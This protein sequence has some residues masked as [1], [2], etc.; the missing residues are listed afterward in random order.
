MIAPALLLASL[1]AAAPAPQRPLPWLW[2]TAPVPAGWTALGDGAWE[3]PAAA[4]EPR[5]AAQIDFLEGRSPAD[6]IK[7]R[8]DPPPAM[9]KV[10]RL[11]SVKAGAVEHRGGWL[12]VEAEE[13]SVDGSKVKAYYAALP[14]PAGVYAAS[15]TGKEP[16]FSAHKAEAVALIEGF[17]RLPPPLRFSALPVPGKFSL[18][19]P[20]GAWRAVV[21]GADADLRAIAP[22]SPGGGAPGMLLASTLDGGAAEAAAFLARSCPGGA[23][24]T[25]S[26][27]AGLWS[28]A[29]ASSRSELVMPEAPAAGGRVY[30]SRCAALARGGRVY[31]LLWTAPPAA[32]DYG[33][34]AFDEALRSLAPAK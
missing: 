2:G 31:T 21:G 1:C 32:Y 10:Q 18:S 30:R 27:E 11:A 14:A 7:V 28:L 4:G 22:L 9:R 16:A 19:A 23:S 8:A 3:P 15:Y 20:A 5:V 24:G 13:T 25:R 26:G 34:P 33:V 29:E 12:V 17:R 6:W